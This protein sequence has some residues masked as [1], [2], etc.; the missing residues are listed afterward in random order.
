MSTQEQIIGRYALHAEIA[1][2]GM[3]TV[4][5][6]RLL[7]PVGFSRTV[8]VK[9]LHPQ[10]AKDPEFVS[11]FLDEARLAARIRH[12]NVVSVLD[13]VALSGELFLVMDYVEGEPLSSLLRAMRKQDDK[14]DLSVA[15]AIVNDALLGLHAAHEAQSAQGTRLNIVHRDVSP[16][17]LL[18][19]VD[20]SCRV[21]DFGVAKA[22]NRLQTTRD[23][24]LKGK[25]SYMSPEQIQSKKVDRRT[26]IYAAG[27]VLWE[28]LVG[29]RL[30]RAEEP[31]AIMAQIITQD[32]ARPSAH[33]ADIPTALDDVVLRALNRDPAERFQTAKEM[34]RALEH[35]LRPA[36]ANAV[37]DWLHAL[38]DS[39]LQERAQTV[40][41]IERFS[42]PGTE[43]GSG[44]PSFAHAPTPIEGTPRISELPLPIPE[45]ASGINVT[46][47][48]NPAGASPQQKWIVGS[49]AAALVFV[50]LVMLASSSSETAETLDSNLTGAHDVAAAAIRDLAEDPPAPSV[51]T[52][53]DAAPSGSASSATSSSPTA[54]PSAPAP[55][56]FP[57]A[58][59]KPRGAWPK[60]KT[61]KW[62]QL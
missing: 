11:M 59:P 61:N 19:G 42:D 57:P 15:S 17:N 30:W 14:V 56:T 2:G 52:S 28:L 9:R 53:P 62:D 8:A 22:A 20:G 43:I 35:A 44:R 6:G 24:Q 48:L 1:S 34:A 25:I 5:I 10:F 26:D 49:V 27:V 40:A 18:V 23:G 54:R 33:R 13:V 7:G 12:R 3:A 38:A 55:S 51:P 4:H 46:H 50:F 36:T 41:R 47:R 32:V 16:Q 37:A 58:T 45:D 60:T 29:R 21:V 39:K 31:A